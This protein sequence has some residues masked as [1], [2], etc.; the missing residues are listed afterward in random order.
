MSEPRRGDVYL[1]SPDP[2]KGRE[3]KKTRPC[4]TVSP[5]ELNAHLSTFIVAPMTTGGHP[6]PFRIPCRFQRK[7]GFVVLDQLRTVDRHRVVRRLGKVTG[8]TLQKILLV[9][10]EMFED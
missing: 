3:T 2:T 1:V 6:Y 5:D 4:V 7:D 9:L 8:S 10:R